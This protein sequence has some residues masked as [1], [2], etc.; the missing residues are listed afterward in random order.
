MC[1]RGLVVRSNYLHSYVLRFYCHLYTC[2]AWVKL[3]CAIVGKESNQRSTAKAGKKNSVYEFRHPTPYP[4]KL[5]KVTRTQLL[6]ANLGRTFSNYLFNHSD[7]PHIEYSHNYHALYC[8]L[9]QVESI[10]HAPTVASS[11]IKL[12]IFILLLCNY[13]GKLVTCV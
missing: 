7:F 12:L 1:V 4:G 6:T 11:R 13:K 9:T 3:I 10:Q 5:S 8:G 2:I